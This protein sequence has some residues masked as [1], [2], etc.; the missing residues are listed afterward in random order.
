VT[1]ETRW[2]VG[3]RELTAMV[4]GPFLFAGLTWVTNIFLLPASPTLQIR[5][6]V[7]V[8]LFIGLVFGPVAGFATGFFGNLLGDFVGGYLAYPPAHPSGNLILDLLNG[9]F[10]NWQIGNGLLGLVTGIAALFYRR[11]YSLLDQVRAVLIALLAVLIGMG[12]ASFTSILVDPALGF[13][14]AVAKYLIP[15]V[16]VDW[17]NV[18]IILPIVLFNY[19]RLDLHSTAWLHSGLL[20]RMAGVILLSAL[21]PV[22]LLGLFLTA[23]TTGAAGSGSSTVLKLGLTVVLTFLFTITNAALVAQSIS[24]PLLRLTGSARA[25]HDGKL[26]S[27]R[28]G[29][30][31]AAAGSDEISELTRMFGQMA[32]EVIQREETLRQ[33]VAE[34]KI[35]IDETKT[36]KQVAEVTET[37]YFQDLQRRAARLRARSERAAPRPSG[38]AY[39]S[40]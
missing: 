17:I 13:D 38:L 26:T 8:P 15:V 19:A 35:E 9:V 4:L 21:L 39:Q 20:Q 22:L 23:G 14:G 24:R 34:L 3:R 29:E 6:A 36:A 1:S 30:L 25:M 31:K 28:V 33:Q 37:E 32:G 7:T 27:A 11:Y 18:A 40:I 10:L 12:V 2:P 5:P 16:S